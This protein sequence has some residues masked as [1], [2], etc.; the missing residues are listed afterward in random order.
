M[1]A[2]NF[3]YRTQIRGYTGRKPEFRETLSEM[4]REAIKAI[5][6]S[7]MCLNDGRVER[8]LTEKMTGDDRLPYK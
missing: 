6:N 4:G 3:V 1:N 5:G 7:P 8:Y 2:A